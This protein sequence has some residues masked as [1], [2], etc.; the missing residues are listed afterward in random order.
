MMASGDADDP[1][2]CLGL[3]RAYQD[4]A[5]RSLDECGA[6]S[7]GAASR[8]SAAIASARGVW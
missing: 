4:L 2:A 5:G 3:G 8:R 1:A 6:N 7:H